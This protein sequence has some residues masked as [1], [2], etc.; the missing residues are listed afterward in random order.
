MVQCGKTDAP[1]CTVTGVIQ[2]DNMVKC[3]GV[4]QVSGAEVTHDTIDDA[5]RN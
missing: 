5:Q 1:R 3:D 2:A 4:G